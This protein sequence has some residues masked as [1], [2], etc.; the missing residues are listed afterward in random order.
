MEYATRRTE[1]IISN[2]ISTDKSFRFIHGR[3]VFSS[4]WQR[5]EFFFARVSFCACDSSNA[6]WIMIT[7]VKTKVEVAEEVAAVVQAMKEER[8]M[9]V[10]REARVNVFSLLVE[11]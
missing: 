5:I 8:M 9:T 11:C 1:K 7:T 10:K 6:R 4:V 2:A 3:S